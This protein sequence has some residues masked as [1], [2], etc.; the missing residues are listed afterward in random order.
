MF[1]QL[2]DE[3]CVSVEYLDKYNKTLI[4]KLGLIKLESNKFNYFSCVE[5][6]RIKEVLGDDYKTLIGTLKP[7]HLSYGNGEPMYT[8]ANGWYFIEIA[9]GDAKWHE[10]KPNDKQEYTRI[11]AEHLRIPLTYAKEIVNT[12]TKERLVDTVEELK[13]IWLNQ[14]NEAINLIKCLKEKYNV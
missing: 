6:K 2:K 11:L 10:V 4:D 13:P 7:L 3:L 14:A 5:S 1:N 12:Y 8:V 9:R